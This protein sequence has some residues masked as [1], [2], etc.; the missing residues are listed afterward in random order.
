[1]GLR[2]IYGLQARIRNVLGLLAAHLLYLLVNDRLR[3]VDNLR[4]S[5]LQLTPHITIRP[6]LRSFGLCLEHGFVSVEL[7]SDAVESGRDDERVV[8]EGV[9]EAAH[10]YRWT[11]AVLGHGQFDAFIVLSICALHLR[12]VSVKLR[13]TD[14]CTP[15]RHVAAESLLA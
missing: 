3:L 11:A 6:P 9:V 5:D 15:T 8:V 2:N 13:L 14:T 12:L 1:M 7:W 4:C 10:V